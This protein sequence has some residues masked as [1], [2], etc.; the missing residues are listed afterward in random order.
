MK[1]VVLLPVAI[2]HP[3]FRMNFLKPATFYLLFLIPIIVLLYFLKLKRKRHVVPSVIL[4]LEAIEDMKANVPFA[5]LRKN[6]L[7]PLQILFL[8]VAILGLAR[9]AWK[10]QTELG[11]QTLLIIDNSASMQATDAKNSRFESAKL[12]AIKLVESLNPSDRMLIIEAGATPT[13]TVTFKSDKLKLK[14]AIE[15]LR[16]YDVVSDMKMALELAASTAKG[17]EGAEI[18]ILTDTTVGEGSSSIN[19]EVWLSHLSRAK[20]HIF[21]KSCNNVAITGFNVSKNHSETVKYQVF[22]ELMNF[23]EIEQNP[24][25]YL[26]IDGR[27]IDG[28]VV[29]LLPEDR[30][31]ILFSD[32]DDQNFEQNVLQIELELENDLKVDNVAYAILRKEQKLRVLLVSEEKSL[33][34]EKAIE[35]QP[36]VSLNTISPR[37]YLGPTD[38]DIVIFNNFVPEDIPEGNAI[39]I[40]PKA[41]LPFM[42]VTTENILTSIISVNETHPLMDSVALAGFKVSSYLKYELPDWGIPLAETTD[43]PLIWLGEQEDRKVIVFAFD[44]FNREVSQFPLSYACPILMANCLNWLGPAFRPIEK[45]SLKVGEPVAINLSHPD[46]IEQVNVKYPDGNPVGSGVKPPN[47]GDGNISQNLF[48]GEEKIIFSETFLTGAYEVW[49]D[50]ELYGKFAVNLLDEQESNIMPIFPR[51]SS[52]ETETT[53]T[54]LTTQK[55]FWHW[56]VFIALAVLIFEWWVY[57][58]HVLD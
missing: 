10:G 17:L 23:G 48:S 6:L 31:T 56:F 41:G 12:H 57:H 1:N 33:F 58:R 9:P 52:M 49:V 44:A 19:Q 32:I 29:N 20:T 7:L 8:L 13:I 51:Q 15:K 21:G 25:A 5:R 18:V 27:I 54:S 46:E 38:N 24:T 34:L 47:N 42:S 39:F 36:N 14:D 11:K 22:A 53:T 50:D 55:E 45:D 26:A 43:S 40:N 2:L 3:S 30:K 16:S 35:T 4:W 28:K 37:E